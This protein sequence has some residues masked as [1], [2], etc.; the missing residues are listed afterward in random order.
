MGPASAY[1]G[2]KYGGAP[3]SGGFIRKPE[4]YEGALSSSEMN[5]FIDAQQAEK[6]ELRLEY[7]DEVN[8][9]FGPGTV[10][11]DARIEEL[12]DYLGPIR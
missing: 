1:A 10:S 9:R 3:T 5:A 2:H 12:R 6:E 8:S 7:V 4:G 11:Q